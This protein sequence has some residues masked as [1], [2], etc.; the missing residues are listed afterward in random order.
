MAKALNGYRIL[1]TKVIFTLMLLTVAFTRNLDPTS[2]IPHQVFDYT[3]YLLLAVCALGR[4]YT[5][6]F[7]GGYKNKQLITYGPFSMVRNPLYFFSLVG[8]IGIAFLSNRLIIGTALIVS[9]FVIFSRLI[10][11]EEK[12]LQSEFGEPYNQYM[13]KV[14]RLLPNPRL[15]QCPQEIVMTPKYLTN[16]FKD[17]IWWFVAFPVFEIIEKLQD[18]DKIPTYF[19]LP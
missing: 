15:Y 18:L 4:L 10:S 6:A 14:P 19:F 7:I 11:R 12:F 13:G 2:S 17:A 3:G 8:I 5:T 9:F 16:A 1:A